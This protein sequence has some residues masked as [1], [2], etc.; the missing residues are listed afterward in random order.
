M[1]FF[2][3]GNSVPKTMSIA[4][5]DEKQN[6]CFPGKELHWQC[7]LLFY[8]TSKGHSRVKNQGSVF[9]QESG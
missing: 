2:D 8:S 9:Q 3:A 1:Y 4:S 5:K 7:N 6:P